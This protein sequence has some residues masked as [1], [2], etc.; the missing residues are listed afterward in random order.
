MKCYMCVNIS[1]SDEHT[2]PKSFFP[3]ANRLNLIKV[4]SCS[5]HNEETSLDDEYVRNLIV[6]TKG[7][8]K[9]AQK[10]FNDKVLPSIKRRNSMMKLMTKNS[11]SMNYI[12][13][14]ENS[15]SLAHEID[16]NR[17]DKVM[18][19]IAYGVYYFS[20]GETWYRKLNVSTNMLYTDSMRNDPIAEEIQNQKNKKK[21]EISYKGSNPEVFKY[22]FL[23]LKT[24]SN[25][26]LVL[27]FYDWFEVWI[28][29]Q[30]DSFESSLEL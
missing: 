19:K 14:D 25:K 18:R 21:I 22:S 5:I 13:G 29:P 15:K 24:N 26:I 27:M 7:N 10:H 4:P 9:I 2:P 12:K 1:T 20:F 30:I 28:I 17:F 16:R 3:K 23:N 8:N 11:I 6:L